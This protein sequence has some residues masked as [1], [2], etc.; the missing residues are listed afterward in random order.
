VPKI[1]FL[2]IVKRCLPKRIKVLLRVCFSKE[3]SK[4]QLK[5]RKTLSLNIHLVDH[6]NLNCKGCDNF[7]SIADEKYHSVESL[8][9]DFNRIYELAN[10][11]I[12]LIHLMGG[13]PLLHPELLKILDIAG[14]NFGK[15]GLMLITNGVLLSKQKEHFWESCHKNN[16]KITIT[17]YPIDLPFAQFEQT[18]KEHNVILKYYQ[19]TGVE[20]NMM[21]KMPINTCG[22]ENY[23]KSFELCFKA[24]TCIMLDEGK[25]YTCAT[26]PYIKYFNKHFG[27]DLQIS[28]KDYIDIYEIKSIDEVFEFLC[29]PMPF[30]RYCNSKELVYGIDWAVSKKEITEWV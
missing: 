30:C 24:N 18:A 3:L 12:D 5:Q 2:Q 29:K 8:E 13:E 15:T 1:T 9:R 14:K 10:G 17:K 25:I 22:T 23:R 4:L 28:K 26:I 6:C 16:I 7:S 11:K 20:L 27:M 19:N 21:H